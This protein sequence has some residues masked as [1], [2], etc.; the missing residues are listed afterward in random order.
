MQTMK[1]LSIGEVARRAGLK[2]SAIRYYEASGVLREPARV[3]GWRRYGDDVFVTLAAIELAQQAGF[4]LAEIRTLL[5]GGTPSRTPRWPSLARRKLAEVDALIARA[6][7]MKRLLMQGIECGCVDLAA[8]PIIAQ[9]VGMMTGRRTRQRARPDPPRS[10][11][12]R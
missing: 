12:S 9:R 5:R 3:S 7:A 10:V 4:S 8:C 11:A 6:L 1:G 2:P